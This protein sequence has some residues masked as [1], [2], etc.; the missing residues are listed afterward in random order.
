MADKERTI[1]SKES[2]L[3]AD[4]LP[5]EAVEAEEWGGWILIRTLTGRQRDRLEADLLTGK[6][7]GQINLDNV[8]AKMVVA[9]AV[10]Q[11]GNQLHQPGDEVKYTVLYT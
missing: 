4:D 9:T 5:T 11:D 10:D 3:T 8:R 6:K 2:I 1:L 7:N